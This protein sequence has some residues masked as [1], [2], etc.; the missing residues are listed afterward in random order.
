MKKVISLAVSAGIVLG[1]AGIGNA[2]VL[3]RKKLYQTKR[4]KKKRLIGGPISTPE[5]VF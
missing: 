2:V 5:L 4:I 3:N 1:T